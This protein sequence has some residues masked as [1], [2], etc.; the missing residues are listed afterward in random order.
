MISFIYSVFIFL[1]FNNRG[2]YMRLK[3][4]QINEAGRKQR[5]FL[6]AQNMSSELSTENVGMFSLVQGA[7]RLQTRRE[8]EM[9]RHE[10]R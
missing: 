10:P 1:S 7:V 6:D 3:N 4:R 2:L 9:C 8:S 5:I